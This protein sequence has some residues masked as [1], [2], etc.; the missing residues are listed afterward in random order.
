[1]NSIKP[2][3]WSVLVVER[4]YYKGY[5]FDFGRFLIDKAPKTQYPI[6]KVL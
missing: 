1:M 2:T 6:G 3:S 4:H 5:L